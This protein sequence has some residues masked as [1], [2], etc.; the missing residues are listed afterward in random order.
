MAEVEKNNSP[1]W[2]QKELTSSDSEKESAKVT[3]NIK[4]ELW[5]LKDQ[6]GQLLKKKLPQKL[7][8]SSEISQLKSSQRFNKMKI[9]TK[10]MLIF[11][12]L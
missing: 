7:K 4:Q 10:K 1:E 5:D 8:H 6:I 9:F 2:S 12:I 11:S 3:E